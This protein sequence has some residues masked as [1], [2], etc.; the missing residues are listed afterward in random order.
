MGNDILITNTTLLPLEPDMPELVANGYL[1]VRDGKIAVLGAMADLA[2]PAATTVIDGS[3]SL[4]MPGLVNCHTHSPMTLFRGLA[5]D[6]PLF[7]A[8]IDH[9]PAPRTGSGPS[10]VEE[11]LAD[12]NPDTLTP[13]QAMEAL[14]ELRGMLKD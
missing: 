13:L 5:D 11:R 8:M 12:I 1:A 4:L 3:G 2:E 10:A 9:Q 7:Q 6:L 14:Y